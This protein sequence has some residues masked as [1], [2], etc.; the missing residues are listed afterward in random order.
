MIWIWADPVRGSHAFSNT[1]STAQC[2]QTQSN[3]V[4]TGV[5]HCGASIVSRRPFDVV[6]AGRAGGSSHDLLVDPR[7]ADA[8]G[9]QRVICVI[10]ANDYARS[11]G[12]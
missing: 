10:L 4:S 1:T 9:N 7:C 2:N 5:Y 8:G 12:V 3:A 11:S 6:F